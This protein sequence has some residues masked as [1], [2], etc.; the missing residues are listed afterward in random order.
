MPNLREMFY[1]FGAFTTNTV[2][3]DCQPN[4]ANRHIVNNLPVYPFH[5]DF[6]P[7]FHLILDICHNISKYILLS[8]MYDTQF[9][10]ISPIF[11]HSFLKM[12]EAPFISDSVHLLIFLHSQFNNHI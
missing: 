7:H 12:F 8:A 10:L 6:I 2:N 9:V 5:C 4:N 11:P 1:I 3:V